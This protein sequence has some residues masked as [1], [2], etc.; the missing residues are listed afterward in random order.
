MKPV[1]VLYATREGH[2]SHVAEHIA[3]AVQSQGVS[4]AVVDVAQPPVDLSIRDYCAVIVAASVHKGKHE[5][6]MTRFI[7][8]HLSELEC[9]PTAFLSVSLSEAGVEDP[10]APAE[11]RAQAATDVQRMINT[12][13]ADTGWHPSRIQAVAGALLYSKYNFILRG[14]MKRIARRAGGD[15]DTT[16][17]YEYTDWKGLDEFVRDF[18]SAAVHP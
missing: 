13:L 8:R 5:R 6:E 10:A 7:K 16:R 17:D 4:S 9:I 11:R 15:T 14:I 18:M 12:F 1:L 3:G 2:T